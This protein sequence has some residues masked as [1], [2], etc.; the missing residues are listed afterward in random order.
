MD[1]EFALIVTIVLFVL[2][3]MSPREEIGGDGVDRERE[4][5]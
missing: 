4:R 5:V 1:M 3:V 2:A